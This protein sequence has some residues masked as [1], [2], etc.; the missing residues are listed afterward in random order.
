MTDS[1]GRYQLQDR[2]AI[3]GTAEVFRARLMAS[4]G[5]E[6]PVVI[7]RVLPQFARDERF[8]RLFDE[9][10]RVAMGVDHPNIV[11]VLDHGTMGETCFIAMELVEGKNLAQLLASAQSRG[12][13]LPAGLAA[14]I[15]AQV[16]EALSFIHHRTSSGGTPL[17]IIHRDVSPQNIL[18]SWA[19]E[20]KLTDFG[21]AKSTVRQEKT[22]DGTL[23]GKLEYMAPEQ[24]RLSEVD[25]RADIF[26]L[27]CVLYE[28]IQGAPPFRGDNELETLERLRRGVMEVSP[29]ELA[30]EEL[31]TQVLV[32]ALALRRE[33]RYQKARE[34]VNDLELFIER[35]A[36]PLGPEVLGLW[37]K[38]VATATAPPAVNAVDLAV[39]R[40]LG[41][42]VEEPPAAPVAT[43]VFAS[44]PTAVEPSHAD[45][46]PRADAGPAARAPRKPLNIVLLVVASL[47]IC[48]W[49]L[50]AYHH[51]ARQDRPSPVASVQADAGP[52]PA[53]PARPPPG[54]VGPGPAALPPAA[55]GKPRR[56]RPRPRPAGSITINSLPWSRVR[57]D[58][59]LVGDTPVVKLRLP[60]GMHRL[61]LLSPRGTVRKSLRV[62]VPVG[63]NKTYSFDL[64]RKP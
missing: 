53:L 44:A 48:G 16:G 9:E 36:R 40:L 30:T 43:S 22:V 61:E 11:G 63:R 20:V 62:S 31:L 59:K 6:R 12:R 25:H 10:A 32:R 17:K 33:D 4:D 28:M 56:S 3:G 23:R 7:K 58:G 14:F 47:G 8:R 15:T 64:T 50:W 60:A 24:A 13:E 42:G 2:I 21:I 18:V 38:E 41:Q 27:G 57:L 35:Q 45:A 51:F 55:M 39:Q 5:S 52:S 46:V 54:D 49:L 37:V 19:G 29:M 26:S 34:L 1:S